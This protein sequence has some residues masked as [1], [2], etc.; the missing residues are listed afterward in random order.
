MVESE[1][2]AFHRRVT[3]N[4]GAIARTPCAVSPTSSARVSRRW[5]SAV[6][7]SRVPSLSFRRSMA[8]PFHEPSP[9]HVST[10]NSARPSAPAGLPSGR[11]SASANSALMAEVN[12]LR[13]FKRQVPSASRRAVV[14]L[15][16]TSEPPAVSVIHWPLIQ[17]V[18]GSRLRRCGSTRS[19]S[20]AFDAS[21]SAVAT[22]S[23]IASG[24]E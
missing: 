10:P 14:S 24:Q 8:M 4:T 9:L 18:A 2:N 6:G 3:C 11:A 15:I 12:H 23:V 17:N 5:I 13:P 7:S 21:R 16:P 19:R 1:P 20:P 22:P